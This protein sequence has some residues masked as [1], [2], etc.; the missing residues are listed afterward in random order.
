MDRNDFT[1][2][3]IIGHRGAPRL[4]RENT[5]FSFQKAV[6]MGCDGLEL[7]V[8]R[9]KDGI[10]IA[11]HDAYIGNS[12]ITDLLYIQVLEITKKLGYEVSRIKDVAENIPE[13]VL[14]NFELKEEGYEKEFIDSV[15]NY[16]DLRAFV[17]SS[18]YPRVIIEI[19]RLFPNIRT[20]LLL[21]PWVSILYQTFS[22]GDF[23]YFY[24]S[25]FFRKHAV[26]VADF[27][28]PHIF[29]A[30]GWFKNSQNKPLWIWESLRQNTKKETFLKLMEHD[31]VEA[32]IVNSPENF[33]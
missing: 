29:C 30:K 27:L 13:T 8:R 6:E 12:R 2:K 25:L 9:T 20:G 23:R 24:Q 5:L 17:V 3:L 4:A 31:E 26:A 22:K 28:I 19:K 10:F 32:V 16:R 1:K 18:F 11:H 21:G 33:V 14:L 7:D 15:S